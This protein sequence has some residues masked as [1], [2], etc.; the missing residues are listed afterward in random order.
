MK[1]EQDRIDLIAIDG[2]DEL[3]NIEFHVRLHRA[4]NFGLWHLEG[5]Y[6]RQMMAAIKTGNC[7]LGLKSHKDSYGNT[8]P[9][10]TDVKAGTAGSY[11][12]VVQTRG[13]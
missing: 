2:E 13:L 3:A 12:F 4:I 9:A 6:G 7:M 11:E 5:N 1:H 10:R 8:V